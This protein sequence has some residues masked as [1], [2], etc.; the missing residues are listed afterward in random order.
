M[1]V[2]PKCDGK[3]NVYDTCPECDG[4]AKVSRF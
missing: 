2:C 4:D 3:Q 1:C